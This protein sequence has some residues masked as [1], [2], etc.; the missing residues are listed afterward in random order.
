[1][2]RV[3][4]LLADWGLARSRSQA[5]ELIAA[6]KVLYAG[7]K[8]RKPGQVFPAEAA[9]EDFEVLPS[10]LNRYVSR[11]GLKLD[12]A[13]DH[14]SLQVAGWRVLDVGLSTGGFADCLLQRGVKSVVGIDVG[15]DQLSDALKT[16][17]RLISH[18]GLHVKDL[19]AEVAGQVE[20]CVVDVS[21]IS[22]T[23]VF[24]VLAAALPAKVMLLALVKPQFEVGQAGL[25]KGGLVKD[26]ELYEQVRV[27]VS[28]AAAEAG[29]LVKDYFASSVKGKD[30][31]VE[32]FIFADRA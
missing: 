21:F 27:K 31:N 26:K 29:F 13:L 22:L 7:E 6:G 10:D 1:L 15:H 28:Q 20:L 17:P 9:K 32:F 19:T 4:R 3:D 30:G 18:E 5:A 12:G 2:K 8:V 11:G 16:D 24:P 23:Q 25:G 14:L